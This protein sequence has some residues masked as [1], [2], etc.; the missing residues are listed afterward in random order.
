[1]E[2]KELDAIVSK[3]KEQLPEAMK[4]QIDEAVK[5]FVTADTIKGLVSIDQYNELK[6]AMEAQGLKMKELESKGANPNK[7]VAELLTE[8][9][10]EFDSLERNKSGFVTIKV[11]KTAVL[12]SAVGSSTLAMRD[13][14]VGQ[15]ARPTNR[16]RPLF[17]TPIPVPAGMGGTVRYFDQTTNTNNAAGQTE[18]SLKGEGVLAW[19][20][21]SLNLRTYAEFLPVSKQSLR[22]FSFI[23]G[24]IRNKLIRDLEYKIDGA[25]FSGSGNAPDIKGVYTSATAYADPAAGITAD[26]SIYDLIAY[27]HGVISKDAP[28]QPNYVLMNMA[29]VTTMKLKKDLNNNYVLPPFTSADG[30]TI[31]GIVVVPTSQVTAGTMLV[32]DFRYATLYTGEDMTISVGFQNDDF[33]KNKVTILAEEELA[34]LVRNVDAGAFIKVADISAA[35]TGLTK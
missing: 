9:K 16:I 10:D 21:Y 28:Y 31:D 6:S 7:S 19:N 4:S 29:D 5:G 17:G 25:L 12:T 8:K 23:E 13:S 14:N 1:M 18:G 26:A 24:E 3:I 2:Q 34:L 11:N 30:M 22:Y 35:L 15:I 32:G 27:I 20:E 33:T